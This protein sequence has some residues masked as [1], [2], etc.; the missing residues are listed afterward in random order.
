MPQDTTNQTP[1]VAATRPSWSARFKTTFIS[2]LIVIVPMGLTVYVV[3]AIVS[4][5]D[6][7]FD[8]LPEPWRPSDVLFPGAGL[9]LAVAIILM[10][11]FIGHNLIGAA[12][13]SAL[14]S[15]IERIPMVA[16]LYRVLRQVAEALLAQGNA[17]AFKKVVLIE[18]PRRGVWSLAFVTSE[19]QGELA[20]RLG[21]VAAN[22]TLLNL[23]IPTTPN[24]TGGFH[25]IASSRDCRPTTMGVEDALKMIISCG[26]VP[27]TPSASTGSR[28]MVAK[29]S[30]GGA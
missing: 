2:G 8:L 25:F 27:P 24:P 15:A 23:F 21:D 17:R 16:S 26:A 20:Q 12:L 14:N 18:W 22:D 13:V 1:T 3:H 6:E 7:I 9:L 28:A 10:A 5:A 11:G 19:V 29:P 4:S 30:D